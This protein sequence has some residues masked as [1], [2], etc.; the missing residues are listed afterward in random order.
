MSTVRIMA[1][2]T[3]TAANDV[4]VGTAEDTQQNIVKD[5][6]EG[7][8]LAALYQSYAPVIY[9]RC[10]RILNS[11]TAAHDATQETFVRLLGRSRPVLTGTQGLYYL[12]EVSTNICLNMLRGQRVRELAV[13]ELTLRAARAGSSETGHA[14][15]Q[16]V[17]ALLSRC[18][19]TSA[20]I[21][22]MHYIDG[23][24]QV[25]VA[26]VLSITRKTVFNR[27]RKLEA[28]A[29]DLL[30]SFKNEKR[31]GWQD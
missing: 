14:D 15:R 21:A 8:A 26:S 10:R 29:S 6:T 30:S 25:E 2:A 28:M 27:L 31:T 12:Y 18:D 11:T 3:G 20:T 4:K 17:T 19:Q 13:P 23:M 1:F 24:T 22:V 9:A 7:A 16:F 5:D